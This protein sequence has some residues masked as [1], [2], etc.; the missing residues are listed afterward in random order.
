[1]M[2]TVPYE[3]ASHADENMNSNILICNTLSVLKMSEIT[4]KIMKSQ[5]HGIIINISSNIALSPFP[6]FTTYSATK[7]FVSTLSDTL[8][9]EYKEYGITIQNVIPNQVTTNMSKDLH[10]DAVAV[11][12]KSYVQYALKTVGKERETSAHP[13]HK[14]FAA[15]SRFMFWWLPES[16]T[17]PMRTSVAKGARETALKQQ[18]NNAQT[19]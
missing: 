4:L 12:A 13:K 1:M 2:D 7:T 6:L 8:Q 17:S 14:F 18:N 11:P 9:D 16:L 10:V 19:I 3:F 5:R 15:I